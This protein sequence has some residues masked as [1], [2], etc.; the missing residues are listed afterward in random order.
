[1][2]RRGT[3]IFC[4]P[5]PARQSARDTGDGFTID[6]PRGAIDMMTPAAFERRFGL[7][8]PDTSRGARLAALRFA[9]GDGRCCNAMG[10]VLVLNPRMM[11]KSG[12]VFG[13]DHGRSAGI[14]L[15]R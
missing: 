5:L 6:L 1:M 2:S 3:A 14:R 7:P 15:T 13:Q 4:W 12:P 10:A 11:P 8:A 9:V